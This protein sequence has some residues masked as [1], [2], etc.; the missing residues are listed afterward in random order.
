MGMNGSLCLIMESN[1]AAGNGGK[2]I[3]CVDNLISSQ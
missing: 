2:G 1:E 3:G